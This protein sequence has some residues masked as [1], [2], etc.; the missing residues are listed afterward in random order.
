M[1]RLTTEELTLAQADDTQTYRQA[2]P[3]ATQAE[4]S[5]V[6]LTAWRG[7]CSSL[8]N[9]QHAPSSAQDGHPILAWNALKYHGLVQL[10]PIFSSFSSSSPFFDP[11]LPCHSSF[12]NLEKLAPG[13]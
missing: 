7:L 5:F 1:G 11:L 3:S 2:D 12:A 10:P 9:H 13:S 4:T 6:A 8:C